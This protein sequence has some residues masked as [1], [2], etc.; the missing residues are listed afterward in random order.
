MTTVFLV[1]AVVTLLLTLNALRP[2]P[3]TWL[4][5]LTFFTGWIASEL[6]PFHLVIH[7]LV[8]AAFVSAGAVEG[9]AGAVALGTAAVTAIGLIVL[10]RQAHRV[11]DVVE[12]ALREGLG[13]DYAD[14]I[15]PEFLD[16]HDP[17]V[18][19]RAL[20]LPFRW[21]HKDVRRI[22][23]VSYGP[24]GHRNKLDVYQPRE[25]GSGR[26]VLF[27]IHGGGWVV[28]DKR[29]QGIPLMLHMAAR[30]WVCVATNYRLSPRATFPDHLVDL[31]KSLAWVREH[32][33]EYGGD[34]EFVVVTGGSA[35][36]HLTALVGLT[37]NDP[38]FQP[39][40]EDV[41]TSVAA[42]VPYY[43][44][45]DFINDF[46]IKAN[47]QR[48]RFFLE[49][50]VMKCRRD[51]NPDLWRK[52]SPQALVTPDDPPFF[53]IHGH[54][55]TLVPVQ[56]ARQFVA[57]LRSTC[58]GPIVYA[59]LPGAQHAFDM[60]PSL[61]TG[62]VVRAVERFLDYVYSGHL[63]AKVEVES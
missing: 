22:R 48:A 41:D 31:K 21:R 49:R 36:G 26:P 45:Y 3:V 38:D 59:E 57:K 47:E 5:V 13:D 35:G 61:R 58:R 51:E 1:W 32:I 8:T 18:P 29:E 43:G 7:L 33:A 40:F 62:H 53:V 54:H 52:A 25:E 28:G 11:G 30:G 37:Q 56:E 34:P 16:R 50:V 24:Y 15:S 55:D 9:T 44:V 60:F 2:L 23:N 39:G 46:G 12:A 17:R 6:A 10:I 63:S 20:A 14:H 19:L 42:A 4:S 27:Q